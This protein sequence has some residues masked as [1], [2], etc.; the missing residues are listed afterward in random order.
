AHDQ[1]HADRRREMEDQIALADETV[2]HGLVGDRLDGKVKVR[3]GRQVRDVLK[4]ACGEVVDDR[5]AVTLLQQG[6]GEVAADEARAA[7]NQCVSHMCVLSPESIHAAPGSTTAS[8]LATGGRSCQRRYLTRNRRSPCVSP[9]T[10]YN[11]L[12]VAYTN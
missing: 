12:Q 7:R 6:F 11:G 9:H 1:V 4:A 8:I 3:V 5:H 2:H 10:I